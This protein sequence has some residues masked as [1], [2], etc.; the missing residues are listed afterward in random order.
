MICE[1]GKTCSSNIA[2]G[3]SSGSQQS[4][5]AKLITNKNNKDNRFTLSVQDCNA[6]SPKQ[7]CMYL[8][9]TSC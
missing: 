1:R 6:R 9:V 2:P 3:A 7:G 8:E 4:Q 5:C